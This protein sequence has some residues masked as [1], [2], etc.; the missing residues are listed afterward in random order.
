MNY[1][2]GHRSHVGFLERRVRA[3]RELRRT[4][5][6][7]RPPLAPRSAR[8][9][10]GAVRSRPGRA[11][12]GLPR[13]RLL[14]PGRP[15]PRRQPRLP[16]ARA[17]AAQAQLPHPARTRRR[18]PAA[19]LTIPGARPALSHTDAPRPAPR[20]L[21]PPPLGGRPPKT[22]RPQRLALRED[23]INHHVTDRPHGQ[24]AD[25]DTVSARSAR[26]GVAHAPL[27][28][29]GSK[30]RKPRYAGDVRARASVHR[31]HPPGVASTHGHTSEAH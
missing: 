19:C 1:E 12:P 5:A 11:S 16:R 26:R 30:S 25:R 17:Q 4:P 29:H 9:A 28:G 20:T 7:A 18:R 13:P 31:R 2:R 27:V 3:L 21:L 10:L 8:A 23:P 22:E 14:R 6:R 15:T 24:V